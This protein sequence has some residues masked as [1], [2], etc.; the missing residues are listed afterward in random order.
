[1]SIDTE[2]SFRYFYDKMGFGPAEFMELPSA[3][4]I[5]RYRGKVPDKML[6]IWQAYGFC[7]FAK[8]LFWTVNPDIYADTLNEW[9]G[10][11]KL[12]FQDNFYVLGR[13]AFGYL[14]VWGTNT[15]KSLKINATDGTIFPRDESDYIKAGRGDF[16]AIRF[17][18][19]RERDDLDFEDDHENPLFNRAL[20]K[21]GQLRADE[22]YG[23]VPALALGG[24]ADLKNLQKVDALVHLSLLAQLGPRKVMRD[25]VLDA[26]RAGLMK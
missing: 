1:M 7:S 26:K 10:D 20:A 14:F 8:G 4:L 17:L 2:P 6:E 5:E 15:G 13:S 3:E 18:A 24:P 16:L 9:V 25:I 19:N 21:L 12:P 22:M 23:F 11:Q